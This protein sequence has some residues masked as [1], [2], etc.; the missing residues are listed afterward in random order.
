MDY[1]GE[2]SLFFRN[3]DKFDRDRFY[4]L[5]KLE[6]KKQN[7]KMSEKGIYRLKFFIKVSICFSKNFVFTRKFAQDLFD[8]YRYYKGKVCSYQL[9]FYLKGLNMEDSDVFYKMLP[10]FKIEKRKENNE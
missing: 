1:D 7:K 2:I 5:F 8:C 10:D 4:E 3:G 6:C 9:F